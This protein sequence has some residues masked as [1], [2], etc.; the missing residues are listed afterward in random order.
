M[1]GFVRKAT[2]ADVDAIC[3]VHYLAHLETYTG[4]VPLA[5]IEENPP[6]SRVRMWSRIIGEHL[7][8]VSVAERDNDIVGF[9]STAPPRDEDPPRDLEL[10][11]IYLLAAHQGIGLGRL[12][13]DATLGER[14]A[15]L[16]V[17]DENARAIEFY[18][19]NGFVPD[20]AEKLDPEHGNIREIRLVRWLWRVRQNRRIL[21]LCIRSNTFYSPLDLSSPFSGCLRFWRLSI[22]TPIEGPTV[23]SPELIGS[24]CGSGRYWRHDS[25]T[26]HRFR[27]HEPHRHDSRRDGYRG[28]DSREVTTPETRRS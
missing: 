3:G 24:I 25:S 6:E 15:S 9:A 17:L 22:R 5:V 10:A 21:A 8:D 14:P 7:G 28:S 11:A 2:L 20:G 27:C 16:W 13:L 1:M 23:P 26:P 4:H 19:R 18:R 12:L